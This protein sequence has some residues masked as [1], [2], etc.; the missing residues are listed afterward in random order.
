MG[1]EMKDYIIG[2]MPATDFLKEF[3]PKTSLKTACK[4]KIFR[5]GCFNKVVSCTSEV[6]AYEPFVGFLDMITIF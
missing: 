6:E 1:K 3:F 4:A 2:P 5:Q